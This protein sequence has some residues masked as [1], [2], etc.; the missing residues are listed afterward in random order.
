MSKTP[1]ESALVPPC[2]QKAEP[3]DI[4]ALRL[5]AKR[6]WT[7]EKNTA[8]LLPNAEQLVEWAVAEYVFGYEIL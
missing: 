4:D 1:Y 6:T 8:E 5:I 2:F 7:P 3:A